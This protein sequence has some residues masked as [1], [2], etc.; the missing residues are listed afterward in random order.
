VRCNRCCWLSPCCCCAQCNTTNHTALQCSSPWSQAT[1]SEALSSPYT[2]SLS[3]PPALLCCTFPRQ[4]P[5]LAV[6]R[7]KALHY[8]TAQVRSALST[9]TYTCTYAET[10]S[11]CM[12]VGMNIASRDSSQH[13]PRQTDQHDSKVMVWVAVSYFGLAFYIFDRMVRKG[14]RPRKDGK[15]VSQCTCHSVWVTCVCV[16]MCRHD[17]RKTGARVRDC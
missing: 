4:L 8:H 16:C 11:R 13:A 12:C 7:R 10:V 2:L 9:F 3:S 6:H 17:E 15:G 5:S 1:R 14:Q